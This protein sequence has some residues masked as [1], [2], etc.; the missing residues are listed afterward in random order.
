MGLVS[1]LHT[2]G[3]AVIK[4]LPLLH[5]LKFLQLC[6]LASFI[7]V[8]RMAQQDELKL[9]IRIHSLYQIFNQSGRLPFSIVRLQ[10]DPA[11]RVVGLRVP[12]PWV[13]PATLMGSHGSG[14]KYL[15][16]PDPWMGTQWV[17]GPSLG[18]GSLG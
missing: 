17:I 2:C 14:L 12:A 10:T 15:W 1:T 16:G 7:F 18:P 9:H 11:G 8:S 4:F 5:N 13:G 3:R 6:P